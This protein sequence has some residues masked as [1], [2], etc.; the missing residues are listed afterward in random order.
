MPRNPERQYFSPYLYVGGHPLLLTDPSGEFGIGN[1]GGIV[2]SG[3]QIAAGGLVVGAG[4]LTGDTAVMAAGG[5]LIG[6]GA[7]AMDYSIVAK[8]YSQSKFF[9]VDAAATVATAEFEAGVLV[10]AES[11]GVGYA[12][13]GGALTGAGGAGYADVFQQ[14]NSHPNA[15]F[16]W[17]EWGIAEGTGA[18]T[19]AVAGGVGYGIGSAL[20]V[21]GADAAVGG[22]LAEAGSGEDDALETPELEAR[23]RKL[24]IGSE[25]EAND[26]FDYK[27]YAGRIVA[28]TTGRFFGGMAGEAFNYGM[29]AWYRG[30]KVKAGQWALD[31]LEVGGDQA[32]TQFATGLVFEAYTPTSASGKAGYAVVKRAVRTGI[33]M[34]WAKLKLS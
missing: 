20:G 24:G 34:G 9:Q 15:K 30:T 29:T 5:A 32:A 31:S 26:G 14:V 13:G 33:G 22:D 4:A 18:I 27:R 7:M 6:G 21:M 3:E 17:G 1:I 25:D 2:L 12:I 23:G 8:H 16:D 11:G 10:S 28:K 19:G